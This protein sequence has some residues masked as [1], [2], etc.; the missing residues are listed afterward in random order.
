MSK[1]FSIFNSHLQLAHLYWKHLLSQADWVIDATC[2]SGFDCAYLTTLV[3]KG[4]VIAIDIQEYAIKKT[5]LLVKEKNTEHV[6]DFFL[7]S[8]ENFPEVVRSHPIKLI[9]YNLGYLP[10]GDRSVVTNA[11]S[12][13]KS[14]ETA[15]TLLAPGGAL[16]VMCYPGHQEGEEEETALAYFFR[17]LSP[18]NWHVC[19]HRWPQRPKTPSLFLAQKIEF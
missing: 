19:H 8:H 5:S 12:S 13:M 11:T 4:R 9:V 2:G 6:V 14:I 15:A 18:K 7:Q 1:G 17:S 3:P 10:S 16:S